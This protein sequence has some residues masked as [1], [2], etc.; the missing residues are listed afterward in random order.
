MRVTLPIHNINSTITRYVVQSV[1]AHLAYYYKIPYDDIIYKEGN[2]PIL[3]R[4]TKTNYPVL[5]QGNKLF[6]NYTELPG[7]NYYNLRKDQHEHPYIF[8]APKIG[9][10]LDPL[11]IRSVIKVNCI[12]RNQTYDVL[13]V[14]LNKYLHELSKSQPFLYNKLEMIVTIN[15]EIID[16]LFKVYDAMELKGGYGDTLKDFSSKYFQTDI[17]ERVNANQSQG[18]LATKINSKMNLT[19][20]QDVEKDI[21]LIPEGGY[22]DV[23]FSLEITYDKFTELVLNYQRFIHNSLVDTSI[24]EKFHDNIKQTSDFKGPIGWTGMILRPLVEDSS[25]IIDPFYDNRDRWY[26][27]DP[28]LLTLFITPIQ[29]NELNLFEVINLNDILTDKLPSWLLLALAQYRTL[30]T[31]KFY[32]FFKVTLYGISDY[33]S[34]VNL[35][36]SENLIITSVDEL[37]IRKRYYL[38]I[39]VIRQ[40]NTVINF[41][42]YFKEIDLIVNILKLFNPNLLTDGSQGNLK[43]LGNNY[44]IDPNSFIEVIKLLNTISPKFLSYYKDNQ[45]FFVNNI[46]LTVIK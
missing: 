38:S 34:E 43:I 24:I 29:V 17:F 39:S 32:F 8:Y 28:D 19:K 2:L 4:D 23:N 1:I 36:I 46:N 21:K 22:Y 30:I 11:S 35:N 44:M 41:D 9:V 3:N 26:P 12:L 7:E 13:Q 45:W 40:I 42:S 18:K 6:V 25:T 20:L 37:D 27:N 16:Y 10:T 14:F 33:Q 5:D 31:T 15:D